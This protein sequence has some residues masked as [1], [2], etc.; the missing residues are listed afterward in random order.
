[1]IKP[2]K[3]TPEQEREVREAVERARH[4]RAQCTEEDGCPFCVT[5]QPA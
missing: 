1:M 5:E 4:P 2:R 3:A